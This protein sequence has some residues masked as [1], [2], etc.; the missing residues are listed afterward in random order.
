MCITPLCIRLSISPS[1]IHLSWRIWWIYWSVCRYGL[2]PAVTES[3][4]RVHVR[5]ASRRPVF[6]VCVLFYL[7]GSADG[8]SL[9]LRETRRRLQALPL[10]L[11]LSLS[12]PQVSGSQSQRS[13]S[14]KHTHAHSHTH[15]LLYFECWLTFSTCPQRW[16]REGENMELWNYGREMNT[17]E[18][19]KTTSVTAE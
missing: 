11:I 14:L 7:S 12:P 19:H 18:H 6:S 1:G 3:Q 10:S 9:N 4:V 17:K 16:D 5:S 2:L 13:S 8:K 15:G